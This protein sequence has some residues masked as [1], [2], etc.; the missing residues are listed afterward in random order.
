M[1]TDVVLD[2]PIP[3][4]IGKDVQEGP[5]APPLFAEGIERVV[6]RVDFAQAILE[7]V[8]GVGREVD[9]L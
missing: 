2:R 4:L 9:E 1:D 6:V 5:A 3:K 8:E 7:V